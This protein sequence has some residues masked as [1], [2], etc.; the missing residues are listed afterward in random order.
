MSL[1]LGGL[2]SVLGHY[3]AADAHFTQSAAMSDRIGAK[4][5]AARTDLLWG[6]MLVDRGATGDTDRARRVLT[7]ARDCAV[8]HNYAN[9]QQL[10]EHELERLHG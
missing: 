2:A 10:A 3:D 5:F 7:R 6:R 9:V 4:F 8:I 1:F